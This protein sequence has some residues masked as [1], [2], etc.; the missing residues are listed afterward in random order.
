MAVTR[1]DP[2]SVSMYV[3]VNSNQ[4]SERLE[5]EVFLELNINFDIHSQILTLP[6]T[7]ENIYIIQRGMYRMIAATKGTEI[8]KIK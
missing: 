8:V 3:A 7:F 2:V 6:Y 4:E 5:V 1:L